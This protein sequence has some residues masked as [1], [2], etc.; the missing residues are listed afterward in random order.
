MHIFVNCGDTYIYIYSLR[1]INT[2]TY[3][4][5]YTYAQVCIHC[6]ASRPTIHW[7][8]EILVCLH[9]Y[10]WVPTPGGGPSESQVWTNIHMLGKRWFRRLMFFF[11]LQVCRGIWVFVFSSTHLR[12]DKHNHVIHGILSPCL[13][14]TQFTPFMFCPHLW[15]HR[16]IS[17]T[18]NSL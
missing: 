4:Y 12:L 10:F 8:S 9:W 14:F 15:E 5:I 7:P 18:S 11:Y 6:A 2:H 16:L 1:Y 3:I 17:S 13:L